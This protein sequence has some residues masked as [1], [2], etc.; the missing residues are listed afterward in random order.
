[1][2]INANG[3]YQCLE[4]V[5]ALNIPNYIHIST[6]YCNVNLKHEPL[7]KEKIYE[8]KLFGDGYELFKEWKDNAERFS[9][10]R[11]KQIYD[12]NVWPNEYSITKNI[13]ELVVDGVCKENNIKF[14]IIRCGIIGGSSLRSDKYW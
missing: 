8:N 4:T 5:K 7:V 6:A 11:V 10:Q 13:A 9:K 3:T 1:M 14:G 2:R 12:R